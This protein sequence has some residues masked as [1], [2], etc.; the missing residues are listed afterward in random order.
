MVKVRGAGSDGFRAK[1]PSSPGRLR[2]TP[3]CIAAA[4]ARFAWAPLAADWFCAWERY[5][6]QPED[7]PRPFGCEQD[8]LQVLQ[9]GRQDCTFKQHRGSSNAWPD[10]VELSSRGGRSWRAGSTDYV[11]MT[12]ICGRGDVWRPDTVDDMLVSTSFSLWLRRT[13]CPA[14][15]DRDHRSTTCRQLKK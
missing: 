12:N 2:R 14:A 1:A 10:E 15:A 3:P 8:E 4:E 5:R 13:L 7:P 6:A 11:N 9:L